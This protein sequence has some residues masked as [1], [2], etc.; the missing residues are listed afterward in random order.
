MGLSLSRKLARAL[1]GDV[2]LLKSE[3][4]RG[5]TFLVTVA[6]GMTRAQTRGATSENKVEKAKFLFSKTSSS[7]T[8][9][10]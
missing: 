2:V 5:S 8:P 1:G 6:A 3:V 7:D 9:L 4:D 10:S